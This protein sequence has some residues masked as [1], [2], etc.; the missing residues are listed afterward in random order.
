MPTI[1]FQNLGDVLDYTFSTGI[2]DSINGDDDTCV[3][4]SGK[5]ALIFYHCD[6]EATLRDNGAIYGGA[7][8]FSSGDEV[9]VLQKENLV[10]VV[11]HTDGVRH[12]EY[13]LRCTFNGSEATI[14]G[15][16]IMVIDKTKISDL[17]DPNYENKYVLPGGL[18]GPF[19]YALDD[20]TFAYLN[21]QGPY[22]TYF[23]VYK[24]VSYEQAE[25]GI[26][27]ES[28]DFELRNTRTNPYQ[29]KEVPLL[30][31]SSNKD[32]LLSNFLMYVSRVNWRQ[33]L[34]RLNLC[35]S[36]VEEIEGKN[37][38]VYTVDFTN[39]YKLQYSIYTKKIAPPKYTI[40]HIDAYT[41]FED[42]NLLNSQGFS[43]LLPLELAPNRDCIT[44]FGLPNHD[45]CYYSYTL[46]R[47]D[48][49]GWVYDYPDNKTR[50][51]SYVINWSDY[52]P[53]DLTMN[54][55]DLC[56]LG[57]E[58]DATF[59]GVSTEYIFHRNYKGYIFNQ[60][61]GCPNI[62]IPFWWTSSLGYTYYDPQ[63]PS[64]YG[65]VYPSPTY[66]GPLFIINDEF[67]QNVYDVEYKMKL[68]PGTYF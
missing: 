6:P 40:D 35:S 65:L 61:Y 18:C 43:N 50:V 42:T 64:Q 5:I 17:S 36:N 13:Y 46:Y 26:S 58:I 57:D 66:T 60:N 53:T 8:G 68:T 12:C 2:I 29:Y 52:I 62:I 24:E 11:G 27:Y 47:W 38:M 41:W 3:L 20:N 25:Y 4:G 10:Y 33:C 7:G 63:I 22:T 14:G 37:Y 34:S 21:Y 19:S 59:G 16:H 28:Y 44:A 9:I 45:D 55:L 32:S 31:F 23:D 56:I 51:T 30:R 1:D 39:L 15:E 54:K 48:G 67:K 49:A